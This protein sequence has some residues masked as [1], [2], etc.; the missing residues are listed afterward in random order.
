MFIT[1]AATKIVFFCCRCSCAFVAMA[2]EGFHRLIMGKLKVCLYFYL[3]ADILTKVLHKCSLSSHLPNVWFLSKLLNLIGCHSNRK[4]KFANKFSKII[5]SEAIRVM[6]LKLYIN[7]H[8]ICL[9]K[10]GIS[11]WYSSCA[12]FCYGNLVSIGL[13]WEKG[14]LAFIAI[15]L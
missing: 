10:S 1:L 5:F 2:T 7:V 14:K 8:N 4:T 15:S 12:F 6:K 11:C 3:T 9:F 13:K